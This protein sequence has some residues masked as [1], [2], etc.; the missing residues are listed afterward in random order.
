MSQFGVLNVSLVTPSKLL[1]EGSV[2]SLTLPTSEG[3]IGIQPG[4]APLLSL[5]GYGALTIHHDKGILKS[6]VLGGFLEV[7]GNDVTILASDAV[8]PAAVDVAEASDSYTEALIMPASSEHERQR[9][10]DALHAARARK[11]F[12]QKNKPE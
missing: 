1:F 2:Q 8:D 11:R 12:G 7:K 9:R 4:H 5:L 3:Y 6:L 10:E